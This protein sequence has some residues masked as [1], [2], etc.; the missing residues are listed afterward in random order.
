MKNLFKNFNENREIFTETI[1]AM[2]TMENG[3]INQGNYRN[4]WNYNKLD[5]KQR[6]I[7]ELWKPWELFELQ[8]LGKSEHFL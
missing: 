6:N 7:W 2:G 8:E 4:L 5:G 1:E 3:N